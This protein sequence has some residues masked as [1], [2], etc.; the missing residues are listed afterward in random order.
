M[1][2]IDPLILI[3]NPL[4]P[5]D[6]R[7]TYEGDMKTIF[8]KY[9]LNEKAKT[10]INAIQT[11][12]KQK[13]L[14][15]KNK[16][17]KGRIVIK[18]FYEKSTLLVNPNLF[19]SVLPL[20]KSFILTFEQKEQLIHRLHRSLDETFRAFLGC[21]TKFEVINDTPYN[22][23]SLIDVASNVRKLKTLYVGDKN[24]KLVSSLRKNKIQRDIANNF[25]RKLP[26]AYVTAAVYIQ[27]K[28]ALNS[29]HL[30]FFCAL[31]PRLRQSSL[32]HENL[33]NLKPYFETFLSSGR[34]EYSPEI[35]KYITDSE[36][37]LQKEQ[38]RLD[39]W[40]N[41][42]FKTN[43]YPVL[44]SLVRPCLS[45]FTGPMVECSFSMM[46][47][48]INSRSGHMEIEAY[49]AIMTTKYSLKSSKS[50]A[51]KFNRK[52][53]LRDPV[54]STLSYYMRTSS[55]RYKKC[56]KTKRDNTVEEK[57]SIVEKSVF[58]SN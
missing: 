31:H 11:K 34:G 37:P 25:Y 6:F 23:L 45:I 27:K 17:R 8:D 21:F 30:K 32:T 7:E 14:T 5:N 48:I 20:F 39:V 15:D 4:I 24:E 1:T 2:L 57:K 41:K 22:K 49:S 53:I 43:R 40:W 26:T 13:K 33:L 16:E 54:D 9:E 47:D 50:A 18:L 38:E 46:N 42:V 52:D 19:M 10:I 12:M 56:L 28:Y 36:L 29:A 51:L 35:H 55:S 58:R 44:S 3:P